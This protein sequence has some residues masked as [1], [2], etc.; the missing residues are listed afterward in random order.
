[1]AWGVQAAVACTL[2][3][4]FRG[5]PPASA[6]PAHDPQPLNQMPGLRVQ[7]PGGQYNMARS[8]FSLVLVPASAVL[9]L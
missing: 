8:C 5:P 2:L 9:V 1:M 7:D 4:L 6:R 3:A